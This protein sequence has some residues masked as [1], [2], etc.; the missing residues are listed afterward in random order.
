MLSLNG[1]K[2][3]YRVNSC[4]GIIEKITSDSLNLAPFSYF[5][6]VMQRIRLYGMLYPWAK[7]GMGTTKDTMI[8][9]PN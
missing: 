4:L 8:R 5:N 7:T 3:S 2:L 9:K 1:P 6:A